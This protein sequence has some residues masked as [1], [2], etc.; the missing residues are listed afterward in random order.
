MQFWSMDLRVV[1]SLAQTI[2]A[3]YGA[4]ASAVAAHA[5][6]QAQQ[7]GDADGAKQWQRVHQSIENLSSAGIPNG[8]IDLLV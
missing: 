7:N 4:N 1:Q 3:R 5:T 6:R 8:K 2:F